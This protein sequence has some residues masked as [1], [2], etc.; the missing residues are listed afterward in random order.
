MIRRFKKF[1][2]DT[3]IGDL[4]DVKVI[5]TGNRITYPIGTWHGDH[6][7]VELPNGE[8]KFTTGFLGDPGETFKINTTKLWSA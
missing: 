5:R 4:I 2:H 3:F 6:T 8:R 1:W 7:L